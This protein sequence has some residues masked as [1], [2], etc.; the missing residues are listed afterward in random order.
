M[1]VNSGGFTLVLR[2]IPFIV[3]CFID[4]PLNVHSQYYK[5]TNGLQN[6]KKGSEIVNTIHD[7]PRIFPH[8]YASAIGSAKSNP[9]KLGLKL[10]GCDAAALERL[11]VCLKLSDSP[12][13]RN[14]AFQ[15]ASQYKVDVAEVSGGR[16]NA[17]KLTLLYDQLG[18]HSE[19]FPKPNQL[20]RNK[21]TGSLQQ[22]LVLLE[23]GDESL[24]NG[25]FTLAGYAF[26]LAVSIGDNESE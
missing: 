7:Y 2:L 16:H 21:L 14:R 25:R 24:W 11:I 12:K 23:Q 17:W 5:S 1:P 13:M 4:V 15:L 22:Y 3:L 6:P 20:I 19:D 9:A 26:L 10:N 8:T 18:S